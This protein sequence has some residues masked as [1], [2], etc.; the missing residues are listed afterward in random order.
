M[1]EPGRWLTWERETH[2]LAQTSLHYASNEYERQRA[3]RLLDFA[4]EMVAAH[5]DLPQE[6]TRAAF[7]AQ[8]G[9][10]TPKV[11]VRGAVFRGDSLLIVQEAMD[12]GWTLPGGWATVF[13]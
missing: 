2:A 9:C 8:P 1:S 12:G 7:T 3:A 4:A 13:H 5:S 6:A 11:D 10:V